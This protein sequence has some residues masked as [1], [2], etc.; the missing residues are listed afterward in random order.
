MDLPEELK[1]HRLFYV[2]NCTTTTP[3]EQAVSVLS[4][5]SPNPAEKMYHF[6]ILASD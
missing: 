2:P 3:N 1:S 4:F 6:P 5:Q